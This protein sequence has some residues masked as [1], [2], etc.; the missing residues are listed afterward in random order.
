MPASGRWCGGSAADVVRARMLVAV[1][2]GRVL[3]SPCALAQQRMSRADDAA[4]TS[5]VVLNSQ[6][7]AGAGLAVHYQE[8]GPGPRADRNVPAPR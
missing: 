7:F 5:L 1:L 3:A 6:A 2:A 8:S 4:P